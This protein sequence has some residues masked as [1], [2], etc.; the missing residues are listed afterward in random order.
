M[1]FPASSLRFESSFC[2]VCCWSVVSKKTISF[3][4]M[5]VDPIFTSISFVGMSFLILKFVLSLGSIS[6]KDEKLLRCLFSLECV[7]W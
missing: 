7:Q 2:A 1:S 6:K 4:A 3:S 5:P